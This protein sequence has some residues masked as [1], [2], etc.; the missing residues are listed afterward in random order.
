MNVLV[1][2]GLELSVYR[3]RS[4]GDQLNICCN[5]ETILKSVYVQDN[6]GNIHV[7]VIRGHCDM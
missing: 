7:F 4:L 3:T 5:E 1:S 6:Y 2:V